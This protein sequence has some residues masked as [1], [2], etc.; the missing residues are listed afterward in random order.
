MTSN[1]SCIETRDCVIDTIQGE[2]F[3]ECNTETNICV[4]S[5]SIGFEGDFCN[6][7]GS[8]IVY[9]IIFNS[10]YV[11]LI[12]IMCFWL[13]FTQ[14]KSYYVFKKMNTIQK[15]NKKQL[16]TS[17]LSISSLLFV[18][19]IYS[20]CSF[21]LSIFLLKGYTDPTFIEFAQDFQV[22]SEEI[23]VIKYFK[24][25]SYVLSVQILSSVVLHLLISLS[26]ISLA[27]RLNEVT[28]MI[29]YLKTLN[30]LKTVFVGLILFICLVLIPALFIVENNFIIIIFVVLYNVLLLALMSGVLYFFSK[31]FKEINNTDAREAYKLIK[32]VTLLHVLAILITL[33]SI[34]MFPISFLEQPKKFQISRV[35]SQFGFVFVYVI[36]LAT[37]IIY[38]K[39][40]LRNYLVIYT[41]HTEEQ[42][43]ISTTQLELN[44][45][46]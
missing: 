23:V 33:F 19:F 20:I 7:T 41:K 32:G 15:Y 6:E 9:N 39:T 28:D 31:L 27:K 36:L 5:S 8:V 38:C 17:T 18:C 29:K 37:D 1:I 21:I 2:I 40:L 45:H 13:F 4:C 24:E 16:K 46:T 11:D 42:L 10:F 26:F 34:I 12:F 44:S 14:F 22:E 30:R 35:L 43:K 25:R 3:G